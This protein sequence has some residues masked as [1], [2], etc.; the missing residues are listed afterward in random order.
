MTVDTKVNSSVDSY[1]LYNVDGDIHKRNHAIL[2]RRMPDNPLEPSFFSQPIETKHQIFPSFDK[3]NHHMYKNDL[4]GFDNMYPV[5]K[6]SENFI[7]PTNVKGPWSGYIHN[8]DQEM[9]LQRPLFA[10]Q[11]YCEQSEYI[12]PNNSHL[13]HSNGP[14]KH[15]VPEKHRSIYARN[16]SDSDELIAKTKNPWNATSRLDFHRNYDS[17]REYKR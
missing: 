13:Y 5:F 1:Q 17:Y 10:N 2:Q 16:Q 12:P 6:P 7:P 15:L 3:N 14:V 4:N 9:I 11:R 8:F